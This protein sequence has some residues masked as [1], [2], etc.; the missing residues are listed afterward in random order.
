MV[1]T[2]PDR[3]GCSTVWSPAVHANPCVERAGRNAVRLC[4]F[5]GQSSVS[6]Q[7]PRSPRGAESSFV[8]RHAV[9]HALA[10][11]RRRYFGCWVRKAPIAQ[12]RIVPLVFG[13][14]S[15]SGPPAVRRVVAGVHVYP[16]DSQVVCVAI[17]K[18]PVAEGRKTFHPLGTY[19]DP[20]PAV[21]LPCN[22][23]RVRAPVEHA[24]PNAKQPGARLA[25]RGSRLSSNLTIE[26]PAGFHSTIPQ[27]LTN[28]D[29]LTP[30]SAGAGP[31]GTTVF[32]PAGK[33]GDGEACKG[34]A[35][36][37]IKGGELLH[38]L[39]VSDKRKGGWA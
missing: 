38:A 23:A 1:L 15:M 30:T 6:Q 20:A 9:R 29:H 19:G 8:A 31:L 24:A 27:L 26:A 10:K 12:P 37:V 21:E 36:D 16:V 25:V 34:L 17:H 33:P 7:V 4:H 35:S 39:M 2:T 32:V 28:S 13:L 22:A 14:L 11:L 18:R 5:D 3:S